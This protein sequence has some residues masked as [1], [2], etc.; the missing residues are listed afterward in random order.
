MIDVDDIKP[1]EIPLSKAASMTS[2]PPSFW[3]LVCQLEI[4]RVR[5]DS[6]K[7]KNI[8]SFAVMRG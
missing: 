7:E 2:L 3:P 5:S 6:I 8:E 1:K 4:I